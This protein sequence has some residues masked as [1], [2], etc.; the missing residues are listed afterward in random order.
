MHPSLRN[1][2]AAAGVLAAIALFT[3]TT[4]FAGPPAAGPTTD[5]AYDFPTVGFYAR[6]DS[7]SWQ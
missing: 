3:P 6:I 5:V 4:S 1:I 2:L 7:T